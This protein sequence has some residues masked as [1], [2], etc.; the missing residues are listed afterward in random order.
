MLPLAVVNCYI[1]RYCC[2][3]ELK[4]THV[5]KGFACL[6]VMFLCFPAIFR[7]VIS[8]M[9]VDVPPL[10]VCLYSWTFYAKHNCIFFIRNFN[11]CY[12]FFNFYFFYIFLNSG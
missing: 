1:T 5:A 12:H 3:A 2:L 8:Q 6:S 10:S 4:Q 11:K 9:C 7:G